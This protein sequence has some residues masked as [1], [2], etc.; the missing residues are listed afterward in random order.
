MSWRRAVGVYS[1]TSEWSHW[2]CSCTCFN[3]K[4]HTGLYTFKIKHLHVKLFKA[5]Q[6]RSAASLVLAQCILNTVEAANTL[7]QFLPKSVAVVVLRHQQWDGRDWEKKG[8]KKGPSKRSSQTDSLIAAWHRA[9][10]CLWKNDHILIWNMCGEWVS[11][12]CVTIWHLVW[13]GPAV[14]VCICMQV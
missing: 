2:G 9:D 4:D 5:F 12:A 3:K 11:G 14:V 8:I 13:S 10:C 7:W 6:K 1:C